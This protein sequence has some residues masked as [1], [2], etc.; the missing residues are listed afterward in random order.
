[1]DIEDKQLV[2][3]RYAARLKE[4]GPSIKAL[5]SGIEE[6]RNIRFGVLTDVGVQNGDTVLDVGCGLGDYG[7]YLKGRGIDVEYCGVD[8]VPELVNSALSMHPDL[9]I[10]VRDI[11]TDPFPDASYDFVVCSQVFNFNFGADKNIALVRDMLSR[12]QKVSRKGVAVDFLTNYVDF[13]E[14]H[15]Y[16]YSPEELFGYAKSL[17]RNVSLRHD[18]PL[19]EFCLYLG[20]DFKGWGRVAK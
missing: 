10:R 20:P 6:R 2:Q 4:H 1:M 16:Y 9:D 8:I 11:Q 3:E 7:S 14:P 15:L 18:Y 13:R 5:A 19:F 12:M 17:T